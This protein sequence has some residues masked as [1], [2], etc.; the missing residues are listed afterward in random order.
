MDRSLLYC[1]RVLYFYY[2]ISRSQWPRG[3]RRGSAAARLLELRVRMPP[4]AWMS[5]SYKYCFL[6]SRSLCVRLIT[7]S[8]ES[9]RVGCDCDREASIMRQ[10]WPT[11]GCS[12]MGGKNT[13]SGR[14]ITNTCMGSLIII[15]SCSTPDRLSM[16][17]SY[18]VT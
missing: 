12:A 2:E 14:N 3:V 9:Y 18:I 11:S 1:D 6:S 10:P 15:N 7:R 16:H 5:A 13:R 17:W 4:G 8:R